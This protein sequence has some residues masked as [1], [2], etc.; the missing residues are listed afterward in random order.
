MMKKSYVSPAANEEVALLRAS[1][2]A[3]SVSGVKQQ[4]SG[5]NPNVPGASGDLD[6]DGARMRVSVD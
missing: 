2:L 4:T 3:G 5:S 1:L 6:D